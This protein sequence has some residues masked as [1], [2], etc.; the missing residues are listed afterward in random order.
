MD[1][2]LISLRY[3]MFATY[4]TTTLIWIFG[5][6]SSFTC[7]SQPSFRSDTIYT[8]YMIDWKHLLIQQFIRLSSSK[9][10]T[11][12]KNQST[13]KEMP[14]GFT[15]AMSTVIGNRLLF[16]L[17]NS[18][19]GPDTEAMMDSKISVSFIQSYSSAAFHVTSI[20]DDYGRD[21]YEL[22]S[23]RSLRSRWWMIDILLRLKLNFLLLCYIL[24]NNH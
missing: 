22:A 2:W 19:R 7:N 17:R 23:L 18:R 6:V 12:T 4:L 8:H 3:S 15:V 5:S 24:E 1:F 20:Q 11:K 10:K 9:T 16:N 13:T 14:I 21:V